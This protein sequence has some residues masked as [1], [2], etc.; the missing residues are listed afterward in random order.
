MMGHTEE[1][2]ESN[3]TCDITG[4]D[5]KLDIVSKINEEIKNIG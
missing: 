5:Y 2:N 1:V 3:Y 4:M